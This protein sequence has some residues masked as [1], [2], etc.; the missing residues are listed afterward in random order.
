MQGLLNI[1]FIGDHILSLLIFLPL[2]GAFVLLFLKNERC[3]RWI[4]LVT[5]VVD[6]ILAIAVIRGFDPSVHTMQF[7]ERH[8]WIPSFNIQYYLGIDGISVLMVFLTALIGW[9]CV[10]ASWTA[11][12]KR[13]KEFNIALLVMQTAMLGVFCSLDFLLFYIFWE[14]ML[15]PM[16]LIIGVWGGPNRI[17]SAFKL[18]LYTLAGSIL[19]LVGMISLYFKGGGTFD[20][21]ALMNQSYTFQFQVF[22]FLLFFIAFAVKVPMFPFHTWLP[23]AH[24]EAPTAGSIILAG[25]LLKMGTYGFL[26]FSF[27]MFPDASK[28]FAVPVIILSLIAIIYGAFLAL[29][30]VDMKK[31][32]A[33]SSVSHMGFVTL[34][35][36][37]FNKTGVEGG[38]LQMFNHGITT[39][40]LFLCVGIIYERTHTRLLD[41]YGWAAKLVPFYA[42]FL[43]LFSMASMGFPGT[44]GFIGELLI[45][46]G[47]YSNYKLYIL[48]LLFG[49]VLGAAYML[50]MYKR[51]AFGAAVGHG[52]GH[53][54]A[55]G[56]THP[57]RIKDVNLREV[58]AILAFL[59]FVFWVGFHPMDFINI[60]D[61]SVDHL[62]T[63]VSGGHALVAEVLVK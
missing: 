22:V 62:L 43:F 53:G 55:H 54:A 46:M 25:V 16:Y 48:F 27:P 6:F 49:I 37:L 8:P 50:W 23:D 21:Q 1:P 33:Y 20:I 19:M 9:I 2:L 7:V 29:A 59:V 13:V 31:L 34:G 10:L 28:F 63:Q 42:F 12:D 38:I 15:I 36:F 17:Y 18:F 14:A 57:G 11:I 44:N 35:L 45:L 24:V 61:A 3:I 39:S 60:M 51:V 47:A 26:R 56:G 41:R 58:V 52:G 30:Q 4:A 32:I 5:T 40:A